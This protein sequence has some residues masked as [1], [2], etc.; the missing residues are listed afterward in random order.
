MLASPNRVASGADLAYQFNRCRSLE[1]LKSACLSSMS[2]TRDASAIPSKTR[3]QTRVPS[4]LTGHECGGTRPYQVRGSR[5]LR[6]SP[7]EIVPLVAQLLAL[8][9]V[10][11]QLPGDAADAIEVIPPGLPAI[12]LPPGWI[13]PAGEVIAVL[14]H[15]HLLNLAVGV[16]AVGRAQH[17]ASDFQLGGPRPVAGDRDLAGQ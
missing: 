3:P 9:R 16:G 7:P 4:K 12:P 1:R 13:T 15:V 14:K 11:R 17:I 10:E 8:V 5:S 2:I 6:R